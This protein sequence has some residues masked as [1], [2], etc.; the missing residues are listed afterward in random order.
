MEMPWR[1]MAAAP[2]D[3]TRILLASED[4]LVIGRWS[5]HDWEISAWGKKGTS[6]FQFEGWLPLIGEK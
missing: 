6:T 3:G 5:G 2:K 1:P 4:H